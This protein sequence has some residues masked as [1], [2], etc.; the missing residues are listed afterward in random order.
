M[1]L[2]VEEAA[3]RGE[4]GKER[5]EK[6]EFQERVLKEFEQLR[7]P[8]W[9]WLDARKSIDALHTD[10]VGIAEAAVAAAASRPLLPLWAPA[11]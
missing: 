1:H 4:F 3:K 5:Y 2:S 11:S 6:R 10:I 9:H 7:E 8:G